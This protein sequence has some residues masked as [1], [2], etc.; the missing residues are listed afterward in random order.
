MAAK[1][2]AEEKARKEL[3]KKEIG[4]RIRELREMQGDTREVLAERANITAKFLYE[5]EV[6]NKGFSAEVLCRLAKAL[7]VS[8]EYIM[9]GE[10][11]RNADKVICVLEKI[12]PKQ[13][14]RMRDILKILSDMCDVI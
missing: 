6:G 14:S 3:A 10:E 5:V 2:T 8:C 1:K 9:T 13:A 7:S 11:Y 4:I 12:E